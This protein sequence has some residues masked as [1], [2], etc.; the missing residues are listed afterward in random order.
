MNIIASNKG[1]FIYFLAIL[2]VG[3]FTCGQTF[4][5]ASQAA[6][7]A[8][9]VQI[10]GD[11]CPSVQVRAGMQ[12]AWTNLDNVDK[13][14]I[15]ESDGDEGTILDLQ[16]TDLLE[17]ADTFSISLNEP[18]HYVYYCSSDRTASGTITVLQ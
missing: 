15:I 5:V 13:A 9:S 17:V 12:I 4:T 6:M 10:I 18:G 3:I 8:I 16:G 7:P 1:T 2:L 11:Y 14:L